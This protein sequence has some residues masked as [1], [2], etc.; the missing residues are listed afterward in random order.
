MSAHP[1]SRGENLA[2]AFN[3]VSL[4][5]SSPLT[6]GK[7]AHC[8]RLALQ[9]GLIPAHAGKTSDP[10]KM[11]S[12]ARAHP[13]SRGENRGRSVR[14]PLLRGS[15][16]LTRG[17]PGGLITPT[18]A[19]RLI[20]AHAGKTPC[21]QRCSFQIPAHPRSRGENP[22]VGRHPGVLEGSSP[23][24]RGKLSD[25]ADVRAT[26]RLIPAH[27]GKTVPD[28]VIGSGDRAH[29]RSRGEN[30]P[31]GAL[32]NIAYGSSPL[33]RGKLTVEVLVAQAVRLI[34]AHAGK[35]RTSAPA[36]P[37]P[38][39]HPRSRGEN[40]ARWRT[41]TR[42][43]GSSP[44]TRG[45]RPRGHVLQRPVRLIPAHAGKTSVTVTAT[46]TAWAHPR[47]RGENE[48]SERSPSSRRGSSP[49]TRGKL[50]LLDLQLNTPRL[51]PAHAGKTA[52]DECSHRPAPAHPRSR[53]ENTSP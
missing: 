40:C 34:P 36:R 13:R 4:I 24:T 20:P 12:A 29:P 15:S 8:L 6:R 47:S 48:M 10:F 53:G 25:V 51:I 45:K 41:R 7:R 9:P 16:P 22:P 21:R 35:T 3:P 19:R 37:S 14:S 50:H 38:S 1:R 17:K 43:R 11:A 42:Q 30:K 28:R 23:L 44:L 32:A 52:P 2:G 49:L 26:E 31:S 46:V 18:P 5:G 33:T 27:A 39:A